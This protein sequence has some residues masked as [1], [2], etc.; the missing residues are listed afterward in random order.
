MGLELECAD[1]R[2]APRTQKRS[3]SIHLGAP[4]GD[5]SV[6]DVDSH[7]ESWLFS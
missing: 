1:V 4:Q 3:V 2:G 7:H 6:R 5:A